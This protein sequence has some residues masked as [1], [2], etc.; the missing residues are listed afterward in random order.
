MSNSLLDHPLIS[1]R[2]FFP[3][4]DTFAEPFWIDCG[5]A[6]LACYYSRNH[7]DARTIVHF[8]GNGEVVGDYLRDFV[9]LFDRMG[10]NI[11]LAEY[12]GYGMSSGAPA[13][14]GMLGD[15]ERIVAAIDQAPEKLVF[16]GRSVGSIYAIHATH[17][18]SNAAGLILESGIADPL[19][20]LLLRVAPREL[21]VTPET[22]EA[23][24]SHDLNH[25][26]KLASFKGASLIMHTCYDG[27]VD[28][29]HGERLYQWVSQPKTLKIFDQGNHNSIQSLN[30]Q[31]YFQLIRTFLQNLPTPE[32]DNA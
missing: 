6:R 18:F 24:V 12:R 23:T 4:Y 28:V 5:Q 17:R 3:R 8:H 19:E 29:S 14:V 2:Y 15:V 26:A 30:Y 13:L 31:A 11:V 25:Q 9:P 32:D 21:K 7:P 20:R 10:Y 16:F 1:Q 22:F 27:L